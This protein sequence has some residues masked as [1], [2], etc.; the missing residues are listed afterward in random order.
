MERLLTVACAALTGGLGSLFVW[1]ALDDATAPGPASATTVTA[2]PAPGSPGG[3]PAPSSLPPVRISPIPGWNPT[4]GNGVATAPGLAGGSTSVQ[5]ELVLAVTPGP[6]TASPG[7]ESVVLSR[8]GAGRG[9]NGQGQGPAFGGGLG[10]V[11]VIDARGSLAGWSATVTLHSVSG[12]D[13]AQVAG[14]RLCVSPAAPA[15]VAGNPAD[16]VRRA[17]S[18]CGAPG[19][20][21][22]LFFAAPGG[23]GGTYTGTAGLSL[24]VPGAPGRSVTADVAVAVH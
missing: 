8:P 15:M 2:T 22:S 11:T 1:G 21:I 24:D 23:G 3:S 13:A 20:P 4:N 7:S 9:P 14:A 5:Q 6:L 18:S 17:P 19:E 10:A 12:L 16:V